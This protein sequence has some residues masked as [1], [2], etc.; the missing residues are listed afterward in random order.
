VV[1]FMSIP[2]GDFEL[3]LQIIF[4]E[5]HVTAICESAPEASFS[6]VFLFLQAARETHGK[7]LTPYLANKYGIE[8]EH[9]TRDQLFDPASQ[10]LR[11]VPASGMP[12]EVALAAGDKRGWG[13][14]SLN[15]HLAD[16][17]QRGWGHSSLNKYLA[18]TA[19][20]HMSIQA[21]RHLRI[22]LLSTVSAAKLKGR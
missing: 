19:Q 8:V 15:K 3:L 14:S 5:W 20:S 6:L 22:S 12:K 21:W 2:T 10:G 17:V 11:M 9:Y 16:T 1:R 13:H 4:L 7:Y 18:D